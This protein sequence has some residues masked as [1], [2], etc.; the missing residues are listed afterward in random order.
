M[1][2]VVYS[3]RKS[4]PEHI[5]HIV[6][7]SGQHKHIEVI[8]VIN[9]GEFSLTEAYNRGLKQAKN[10]I[11]V[12]CH[13]DI[14]IETK[15]W[16]DKLL[17]LF[18][19]N[20][21]FGIIGVAGTKYLPSSGQWWENRKKMY[22]RVAHTH[23][24]K[25]WLSTY[26]DDL[27][28]ELEEVVIVDGVFFAIDKTKIKHDFD[29]SVKGF[30]FYDVTFCFQN[31]LTGVKI[32]VT[33]VLRI[34]HQSIGMT[35]DSWETNKQIFA[36]TYKDKLPVNIKKTLRKGQRLK[37][38][39]G[40]L[41]LNVGTKET[42]YVID[43]LTQ[44]SKNNIDITLVS[45]IDASLIKKIKSL[46]VK[47]FPLQEPPGFKL[48]DGKW[49]L[50]T[51]EGQT[52]STPNTLYNLT[53]VT[54]DILHLNQ[55]PIV[56]HIS[57]LYPNTDTICTIHTTDKTLDEPII[58]PDIKKYIAVEPFIQEVLVDGYK[59]TK[60]LVTMTNDNILEEYK[61]ILS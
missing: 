46:G 19:K 57:R 30:H 56:E 24:G 43:V 39:V 54:F 6:K 61:S 36:E 32:G 42:A 38:L 60:D 35:N 12:F 11:V 23:E 17:K 58:S 21:E 55:K 14:V 34:N 45:N 16:G 9:D 18:N 41:S 49:H 3:T 5:N 1:I 4:K 26:S 47:I 40:C 37:V 48:G 13:D 31:Y 51:A 2:T 52:L 8:E 29:E 20:P 25:T 28:Q 27:G 50:K 44:L 7:S 15:Q 10:N 59:I 33:T 53:N 22:G